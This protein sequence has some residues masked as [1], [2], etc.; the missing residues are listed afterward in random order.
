MRFA[1]IDAE[2][3][4]SH[5]IP[6]AI[7]GRVLA[8]TEGGYWGW[9]GRSPCRR[10]K[11]DEKLGAKIEKFFEESGGSYGAYRMQLHLSKEGCTVGRRRITRLMRERGLSA[12]TRRHWYKTTDSVHSYPMADNVVNREFVVL[13][14]NQLWLTDISYLP[15]TEG[16]LYIAVVLDAFS[17]RVIGYAIEDYMHTSLCED[18]LRMALRNRS[19]LEGGLVHHSD[20]GSQYA[21]HR[22]QRLLHDTNI[23]ASMSRRGN[24]W[25]NAMMESFFGRLKNEHIYQL[26]KRSKQ[27]T[28]ERTLQWIETWY[29]YQRVH[30]SLPN[31]FSPME[32]EN[33]YWQQQLSMTLNIKVA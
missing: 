18:A 17:R 20:R 24:C 31:G 33:H 9:K 15:T 12:Q 30:T 14:P 28:K 3:A 27:R 8:V 1:F 21:S 16:W 22:Y 4:L 26:P 19:I 25:D 6:L 11:E 23:T 29:N 2:R 5:R 7:Y 10:S 32:L 13:R